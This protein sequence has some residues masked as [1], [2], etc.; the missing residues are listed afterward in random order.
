MGSAGPRPA[1]QHGGACRSFPDNARHLRHRSGLAAH[2][3]NAKRP[4]MSRMS[5]C[6]SMP[7]Q[8]ALEE[9]CVETVGGRTVVLARCTV[10]LRRVIRMVCVL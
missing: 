1:V 3:I 5:G 2:E 9:W 6:R 8:N 4:R 7:Q 10:V